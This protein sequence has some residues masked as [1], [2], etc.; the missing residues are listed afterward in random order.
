MR[1]NESSCV[2]STFPIDESLSTALAAIALDAPL[3]DGAVQSQ[4]AG[5][6]LDTPAMAQ[7]PIDAANTRM[8][9]LISTSG[10]TPPMLG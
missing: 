5:Q 2:I 9:E 10:P 7:I 1:I 3:G 6:P 8:R 4:P